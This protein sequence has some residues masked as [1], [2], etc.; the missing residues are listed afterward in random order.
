MKIRLSRTHFS[1]QYGTKI[2]GP[3]PTFP[4]IMEQKFV[5]KNSQISCWKVE[6]FRILGGPEPTFTQHYG[7][8][9]CIKNILKLVARK[10]KISEYYQNVMMVYV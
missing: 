4:S 3:E 10:L 9:I 1:Q 7:T 5:L 2:G 6:N 8:K